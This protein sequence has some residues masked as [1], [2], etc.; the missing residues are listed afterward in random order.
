MP[1]QGQRLGPQLQR[2]R[3]M[4]DRPLQEQEVSREES[5][6]G[7]TS[8]A[9]S[10]SWEQER[11]PVF[12]GGHVWVFRTRADLP[13]R[14]CVRANSLQSCPI[15]WDPMTIALQAPL[16]MGFSRQEYWSGLPCPPP[17]HLPDP[18]AEPAFLAPPALVVEFFPLTPP[19][20]PDPSLYTRSICSVVQVQFF[21]HLS[22]IRLHSSPTEHSPPEG[23]RLTP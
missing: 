11:P 20:K 6:A 2:P 21:L 22:L 5:T 4:A 3:L 15:L 17:G 1:S 18:G 14:V 16:S 12:P 23:P 7:E 13:V 19:G 9:Q 10:G 8:G